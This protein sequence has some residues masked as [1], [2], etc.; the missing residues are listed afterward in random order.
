[1]SLHR[2]ASIY[3]TQV[4]HRRAG[5]PRY[6]FAYRLFSLLLDID[7]LDETAARLRWFSH[8]R[9]NLLAFHDC[10]HGPRDGSALRPWI[11]ALLER[12]N[13]DLEGGTVHLLCLPRLFGYAFNPISVWYCVHRDGT[14][15][16]A[17]CEVHNTFGEQHGY[18][19]HRRGE[20]LTW[21]LRD[22]APK[23]FHVSPL[24]ALE[25]HYRFRL[26]EPDERL[27]VQVHA[28]HDEQLLLA[29]AQAGRGEALSDR[30]IARALLRTPLMTLKVTAAIHWQALKIWL[31][32]APFYPKPKPP[33][34]EVTS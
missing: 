33:Q 2:D 10:D 23:R 11:D 27:S 28:I 34:E 21:P 19:L 5:G 20:A 6:R 14:P 29:A 30:N 31:R 22:Q 1:M 9:F 13:I 18:L 7:R 8:N 15:R 16:A 3:F 17:L 32:G 4:M 12:H 26:G 24:I 25:G